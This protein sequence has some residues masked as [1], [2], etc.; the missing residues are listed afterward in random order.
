MRWKGCRSKTGD[1]QRAANFPGLLASKSASATASRR[2]CWFD[3]WTHKRRCPSLSSSASQSP[4]LKKLEMQKRHFCCLDC[5]RPQLLCPSADLTTVSESLSSRN[6][7]LDIFFRPVPSLLAVPPIVKSR[8]KPTNKMAANVEHGLLG[9]AYREDCRCGD[10]G[11]WIQWITSLVSTRTHSSSFHYLP[12][13]A[14]I[15]TC[16]CLTSYCALYNADALTLCHHIPIWVVWIPP[17]V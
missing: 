17:W 12:W 15:T 2:I 4:L 14:V 10:V 6:W 3:A 13:P 8:R 5:L 1:L 9:L 11:R 7:K 16:F